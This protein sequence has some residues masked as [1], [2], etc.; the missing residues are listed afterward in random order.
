MSVKQKINIFE[1]FLWFWLIFFGNFRCFLLI[2]CYPDPDP[3]YWSWSGSGWPKWNRSKRIRIRNTVYNSKIFKKVFF[4][5]KKIVNLK[6]IVKQK[7][8]T[9]A[10]LVGAE[11]MSIK[12]SKLK[13][14]HSYR[15]LFFHF[16]ILR[17]VSTCS[18]YLL[19]TLPWFD[20]ISVHP[21]G[22]QFVF[23]I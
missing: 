10:L 22:H 17:S 4:F 19:Q 5:T 3:F 6:N 8:Y 16:R 18:L 2:F 7:R 15:N 9:R 12:K 23:S 11:K 20:Q 14:W 1:K 21:S 13:V